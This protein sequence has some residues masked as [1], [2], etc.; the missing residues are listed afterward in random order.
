VTTDFTA[1]R[2][3]PLNSHSHWGRLAV[4]AALDAILGVLALAWPGV[5]VLV[6]ATLL[7]VVL[8]VSGLVSVAIGL[9]LRR[10]GGSGV[11]AIVL[12]A[13]SIVAA[14][15]CLVHL[16]AGVGA[17]ALGAAFWFVLTGLVDLQRSRIDTAHRT[18]WTVVGVLSLIAGVVL[19]VDIGAAVLTVALVVGVSFLL[20]AAGELSLAMRLRR[21][22]RA[23]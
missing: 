12:G 1:P 23:R 19:L 8:L 14:L 7:G 22:D 6:L 4:V 11:A 9:R 2:R 5:T 10:A 13:I 18:W 17:I 3:A 20:R 16:G 21:L 15:V